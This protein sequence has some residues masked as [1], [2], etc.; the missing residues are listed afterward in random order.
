MIELHS[1]RDMRMTYTNYCIPA[2]SV[3]N[4]SVSRPF[5]SLSTWK[6]H[7]KTI[8]LESSDPVALLLPLELEMASI[9]RLVT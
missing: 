6:G 7:D 2:K 8:T 3:W 9:I 1:A 5:L 4:N